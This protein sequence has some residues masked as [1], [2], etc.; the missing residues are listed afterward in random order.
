[1]KKGLKTILAIPALIGLVAVPAMAENSLDLGGEMRV[2]AWMMDYDGGTDSSFFDHRLRMYGKFKVNDNVQVHFRTD[3]TEE[4]WGSTGSTYGAGRLPSNSMQVDRGFLQFENDAML[5]RAGLQY[6]EVSPSA[7]ISTQDEGFVLKI[8]N[9]AAPVTLFAFM[10]D[11]TAGNT[12]IQDEGWA[13]GFG[14]NP[15]VGPADIQVFGGYL[16]NDSSDTDVFLLGA[17]AVVDAGMATVKAEFD[18]FGGDVNATTD[19]K[20]LQGYIGADL[21]IGDTVTVSPTFWYAQSADAGEAQLVVFGNDFGGWDPAFDVGTQLSNE[22][23]GLG[24]PYDFTGAGAGVIGGTLI[25]KVKVSDA[26]SIGAGVNYLTV[27]DDAVYDDSLLGL[28]VGGSYKFMETARIDIQVEYH[29]W[30]NGTD[31]IKGGIYLGT[32]F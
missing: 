24:R 10:D 23:I 31:A 22:K 15:K 18:Y 30:D 19:A 14:V 17:S 32:S 26:A 8:K 1:M 21:K 13:M 20:G 28:V 27:E 7:V 11:D 12:E 6:A 16:T 5:F 29:D 9:D 25:S 4:E 3:L 2:R